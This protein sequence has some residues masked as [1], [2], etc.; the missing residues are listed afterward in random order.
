MMRKILSA[1]EINELCASLRDERMEWIEDNRAR[2]NEF[3]TLLSIGDRENL[4]ILVN[5]IVDR[6]CKMEQIG[7]W[8]TGGDENFLRRAISMLYVEFSYTTDI[9]SEDKVLPVLCGELELNN[10]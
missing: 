1:K 7:R 6:S 2:N 8:I 3:R 5:T 10:R 4:I 9:S